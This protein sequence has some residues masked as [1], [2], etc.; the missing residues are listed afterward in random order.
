MKTWAPAITGMLCLGL[1]PGLIGIYGFF[2]EPLSKEF[3]V[4]VAVLNIG[5]VALILVPGIVAPMIGKLADRLPI[6]SLLLTGASL[7]ML[8]LFAIG[9]A[10]TLL[11]AALGFLCFSF[12]LTMY[13]PVVVNGLM[14]KV[15]PGREA[16][17]LAVAA[18]GISV[19]S[20]TLPPL[21]GNLLVYLDWRST[22]QSLSVALLVALWLVILTGVPRGIVGKAPVG[23][24][25]GGKTF[26][27]EPA[28]WLIG[29]CVALGLNVSIVLAVSYPPYF[30][31]Q[32]YS[33]ADAGW[34]LAISGLAG[35][36]GKTCLAWF[37]D[38]TRYYAKWLAMV[39]LLLQ[40][41]GLGMLLVAEETSEI[42]PALCLLGFGGGAFIPMHPYLNSRYFDSTIISQV[43][44]AQMP[45][46][47]PFGLVGAPLAGYVYDQTGSYDVVLIAL[48]AT[49][50]IA[51]L[52]VLRLPKQ[53]A[54]RS[55]QYQA[56]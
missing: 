55:G 39:L 56:E 21:V 31:S 36:A 28:F 8:S 3:G 13:G 52:L 35:L 19:A 11:L 40:V 4:G 37:G 49:L 2:V 30:S 7:A 41:G 45:L 54:T 20:A 51:A 22:L 34:F 38:A 15:Y 29:L 10:P 44:G 16:R 27:R 5:P 48:A 26:Y 17:A 32:G 53:A 42:I 18:I 24:D 25:L 33:A 47:L 6:R 50:G 9:L 46:F 23:E 1:G 12:G 43:N 14:V